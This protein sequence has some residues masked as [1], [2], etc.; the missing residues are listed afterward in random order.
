MHLVRSTKTLIQNLREEGW[1]K[2]LKN[3]TSFCEKHDIEVPQFSASYVARQGRSR[4]QKDH[5][6]VE[7][8]L[9]V[10]IFF[11]TIDKQLQE[12]NCRFNDQAMELLTLSMTLVPKDA[13]KAFNIED[14][15]TLVDKYYPMDFS[16]QEKINLHFQL[17]HFI[18]DARQDSNLKNLSTMQELCTCLATTK[19]SEVYYLIDRLL[20]LIMTLPVSTATTERSF[21]AMKI[22][23]TRL[24]N[25]MEADF[26][27][28]SMIVY[29]ERDIAT[30]FSSDSIIEHFKSLKERRAAL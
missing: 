28:D 9:R 26:L 17:Q 24:R 27:A 10:E 11:V 16:E 20:R 1:D 25:K 15:C 4:H 30:S 12:L 8:Y 29:I 13:Y 19:K 18:V 6:T 2:L 3:V 7:H 21:S 23:K 14:I 22:I 5:I